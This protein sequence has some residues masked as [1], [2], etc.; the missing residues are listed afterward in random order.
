MDKKG[1][2][3]QCEETQTTNMQGVAVLQA[4]PYRDWSQKERGASQASYSDNST[5]RTRKVRT[6]AKPNMS[7]KFVSGPDFS[8]HS[9]SQEDSKADLH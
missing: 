8:R 2:S 1:Y 3:S 5:L 9:S 7:K 4:H 6:L